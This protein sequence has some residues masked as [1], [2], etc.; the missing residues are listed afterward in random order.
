MF[1]QEGGGEEEEE[2]EEEEEARYS[3]LPQQVETKKKKID[4]FCYPPAGVLR[5]Y[6]YIHI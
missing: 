3:C 1:K 2:E 4:I 6:A 5:T